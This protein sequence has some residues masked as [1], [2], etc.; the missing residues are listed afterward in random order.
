[1]SLTVG[2]LCV[3]AEPDAF[4]QALGGGRFPVAWIGKQRAGPNRLAVVEDVG[5]VVE[6]LF[7]QVFA[8]DFNHAPPPYHPASPVIHEFVTLHFLRN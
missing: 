2:L 6:K 7:D 4:E 3:F 1:V 8:S 5:N